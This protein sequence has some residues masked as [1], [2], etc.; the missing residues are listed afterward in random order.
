MVKIKEK[1]PIIK[2]FEELEI[3]EFFL[4]SGYLFLK[5]SK[6]KEENVFFFEQNKKRSFNQKS[7]IV[8]INTEV[9][10]HEIY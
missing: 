10:Y 5:I 7:Q 4:F 9:L 1:L 6:E 2:T 3:G 8:L